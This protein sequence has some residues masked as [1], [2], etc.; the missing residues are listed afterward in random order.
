[1][2]VS[3]VVFKKDDFKGKNYKNLTE[4]IKLACFITPIFFM[5]L[6]L[7][8]ISKACPTQY[9]SNITS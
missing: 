3:D 8:S 2:G 6:I 4:K 1:M 7:I 9:D 5:Y